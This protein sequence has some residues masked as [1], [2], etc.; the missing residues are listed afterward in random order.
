MSLKLK[1]IS[2][3]SLFMLMLGVLILGVYA[4]TQQ[5][6]SMQGS[7]SF[8]VPD[9]SLYVKEVR[10][11]EAGGE[12]I[13]V[14]SFTPGYINGNFNM[15]LT[16]LN[17]EENGHGS[18]TLYFDI[19]NATDSYWQIADV[20]LS[21][22]TNDGVSERHSG[23]IGVNDLTDSDGDDFKEFDP[24]T[25]Q[26]DGTLELTIMAPNSDSID[27]GEIV[28]TIKEALS[29]TAISTNETLGTATGGGVV[30]IGQ[31]VALSANF[32]DVDGAAF[33]GWRAGSET[34]EL[35]STSFD[36]EFTY[37]DTSAATY[38]AIFEEPDNYL[39]YSYNEDGT[40]GTASV[41]G[42]DTSVI[43]LKIPT[44]TYNSEV[45]PYTFSVTSIG[46]RAFSGCD[47]LTSIVI[48]DSVTSIG[49][50]A[51][52]Y[53]SSLTNITIPDSVTDIDGYAFC[54]CDN[55]EELTIGANVERIGHKAFSDLSVNTI[56]YNA[57]NASLN[58]LY[59][60]TT[61]ATFSGSTITNF[62]FGD[63][64]ETI[65]N[66]FRSYL[67]ED[68]HDKY[69]NNISISNIHIG[70][71]VND[72][73]SEYA[74]SGCQNIKTIY[75]DPEN[76]YFTSRD[77][78]GNELNCLIRLE[79][80]ALIRATDNTTITEGSY[81]YS[82]ITYIEIGAFAGLDNITI[83]LS[84]NV[85]GIGRLAFYYCGFAVTSLVIPES[86]TFIGYYAFQSVTGLETI[87]LNTT[88]NWRVSGNGYASTTVQA[89]S[90]PVNALEYLGSSTYYKR[91]WTAIV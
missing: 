91:D 84:S 54:A 1:L 88:C 56:Y 77:S 35:V 42:C 90:I 40:D 50:Y 83:E 36:Y 63:S 76:Q 87:T 7:L 62:I 29:V 75:V 20:D 22:L 4:A 57:K 16:S 28:I 78:D 14:D 51:F 70:K 9:K 8:V 26:A 27:L 39:T 86:V 41:T 80:M 55:L 60:G 85:T 31:Q 15:D 38:Y 33:L 74:F 59:D 34:G 21:S 25:T 43:G 82:I 89:S 81:L 49:N 32:T 79:D 47:S 2:C 23:I 6:I 52:Y 18:F 10:Y 19:I 73:T 58:Y 24:A 30:E 53:C 71:N 46:D 66:L 12:E 3:I 48:P 13:V 61:I 45:S 11:Q 44:E 68:S 64:V 72:I 37:D 67:E 5:Q 69:Y 17:T 65:P